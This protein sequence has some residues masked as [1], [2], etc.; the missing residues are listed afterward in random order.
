[1][2]ALEDSLPHRQSVQEVLQ[3][4]LLHTEPM[5]ANTYIVQGLGCVSMVALEKVLPHFQGL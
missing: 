4:S 3:G 5:I 1:M 2:A